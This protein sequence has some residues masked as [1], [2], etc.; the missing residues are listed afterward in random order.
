ME[1]GE[2]AQRSSTALRSLNTLRGFRRHTTKATGVTVS[3]G[4]LSLAGLAGGVVELVRD[5]PHALLFGGVGVLLLAAT[6]A[7]HRL[8]GRRLYAA[9]RRD[10]WIAVQAPTG[11]LWDVEAS[12][13]RYGPGPGEPLTLI[14][15]ANLQPAD[16]VRPL[17]AVRRY[18]EGL[19]DAERARLSERIRQAGLS[20]PLPA[21]RFFPDATGCLLDVGRTD[22]VVVIP[23]KYV[24][25]V[26]V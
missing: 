15:A 20:T 13:L 3:L 16:F 23:P 5:Q 6:V 19:T 26:K 7:V 24:I 4:A 21:D 10:G 8:R 14:A 9:F 11:F 22:L 18:L 2:L 17:T 25:P 1:A 12:T